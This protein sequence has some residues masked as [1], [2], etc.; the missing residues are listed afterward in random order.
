MLGLEYKEEN[1]NLLVQLCQER[2]LGFSVVL[3][4][5]RVFSRGRMLILVAVVILLRGI[6]SAAVGGVHL[7]HRTKFSNVKQLGSSQG[8]HFKKCFYWRIGE[9]LSLRHNL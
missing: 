3:R 7:C 4:R 6:R 1:N 8:A 5:S 2:C 9:K